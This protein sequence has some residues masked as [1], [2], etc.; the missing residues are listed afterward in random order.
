MFTYQV[1]YWSWLKLESIEER[2]TKDGE[3]RRLEGELANVA[4]KLKT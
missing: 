3:I 2:V 4:K 1:L